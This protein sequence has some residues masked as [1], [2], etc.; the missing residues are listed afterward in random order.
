MIVNEIF[1]SVQGEGFFTGTPS[2]F[3]RFSGCNLNCSFCDTIHVS[4][5]EMSEDDIIQEVKKYPARHVVITGGEPLIQLTETLIDKLHDIDKFIQ[6]ETNGTRLIDNMCLAKINWITCSPKFEFCKNAKLKLQTIDELK[7]VY[8]G[9]DMSVY[10]NILATEY[11]VQ[12]CDVKD[13]KRNAD[14]ISQTVNFIKSH[15]KWKLSLQ[16][17]KI[18]NVR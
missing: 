12:P 9:Q 11:Y 6:I 13:K 3:I 10:N 14:I 1:Y 15:P 18:L 2:V 7:V 17:Q 4:G 8:T 16:T 5:K